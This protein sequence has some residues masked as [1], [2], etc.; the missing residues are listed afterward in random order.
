MSP[1]RTLSH[2]LR[3]ANS[4]Y[5]RL[6]ERSRLHIDLQ[7]RLESLLAPGTIGHYRVQNLREGI[8]I[9]QADSPS[10]AS[11]LRF[12]LPRLLEQL[13]AMPGLQQLRDIQIRV[14]TASQPRPMPLRRAHLSQQAAAVLESAADATQD[15][16]LREALRRLARKGSA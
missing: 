5:G 8:L 2:L 15:P 6:I 9:L 12:E 10:W 1:A 14:A 3:D 7:A 4:P 16:Q 13:R 11:R